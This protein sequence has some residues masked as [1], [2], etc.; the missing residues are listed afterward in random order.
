[1]M[2]FLYVLNPKSNRLPHDEVATAG[3]E[4]HQVRDDYLVGKSVF[5]S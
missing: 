2:K 3:R 4:L 1:M 5:T